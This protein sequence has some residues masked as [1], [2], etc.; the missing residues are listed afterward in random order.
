MTGTHNQNERVRDQES[1]GGD[2]R[3]SDLSAIRGFPQEQLHSLRDVLSHGVDLVLSDLDYTLTIPNGLHSS[4]IKVVFADL[5][6]S[7]PGIVEEAMRQVRG[8]PY[9]RIFEGVLE[10]C[11]EA[12]ELDCSVDEVWARANL[13]VSQI[14]G[15]VREFESS[16]IPLEGAAAMVDLVGEFDIPLRVC[17]ASPRGFATLSIVR[18]GLIE[19]LASAEIRCAEDTEFPKSDPRYWQ[20]AAG[21]ISMDR[22]LVFEDRA[23]FAAAALQAGAKKVF[24]RPSRAH[25]DVSELIARYPDRFVPVREWSDLL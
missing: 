9:E 25:E 4:L 11:I 12:G 2:P 3:A 15:Q 21:G 23:P 19:S 13:V 6:V 10:R 14:L 17:T 18:A 24:Y 7:D 8:S 5:G 22:V 20:E 1:S 16:P